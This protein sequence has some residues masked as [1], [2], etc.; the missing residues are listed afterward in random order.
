[1]P[2]VTALLS[3]KKLLVFLLSESVTVKTRF[4]NVA[5][6][7]R[8]LLDRKRYQ[9]VFDSFRLISGWAINTKKIL[10]WF[11]INGCAFFHFGSIGILQFSIPTI[12][13][14]PDQNINPLTV[15]NG[16]WIL[17]NEINVPRKPHRQCLTTEL[18]KLKYK[19]KS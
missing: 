13:V 5:F 10:H 9:L 4:N 6:L 12:P 1:M 15:P 19:E 18:S 11:F 8:P 16:L 2:S 14:A 3:N 7:S 17:F